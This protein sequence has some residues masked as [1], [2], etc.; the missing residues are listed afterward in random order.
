MRW[1]L[2]CL[3]LLLASCGPESPADPG[4]VPAGYE[5]LDGGVAI[6]PDTLLDS[7]WCFQPSQSEELVGGSCLLL[8][9]RRP[10]L[11]GD[12]QFSDD[13]GRVWV[14]RLTVDVDD[15]NSSDQLMGVIAGGIESTDRPQVM[16]EWAG[17][18][19]RDG[20]L[21][22]SRWE[23]EGR[24]PSLRGSVAWTR[25]IALAVRTR[26]GTYVIRVQWWPNGDGDVAG[27]RGATTVPS[28]RTV[29]EYVT[30]DWAVFR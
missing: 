25:V 1:A 19:V 14:I 10:S 20:E 23:C 5:P 16:K 18:D 29:A 21:W 28:T 8:A 6:R 30:T 3:L 15:P 22:R 9:E 12:R 26:T 13:G 17:A 11:S 7:A 4:W 24:S 2:G 27:L